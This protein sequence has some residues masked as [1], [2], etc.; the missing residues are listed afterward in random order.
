MLSP[1]DTILIF[2]VALLLFGPEHLPKIARQLGDAMRHVQTTTNAFMAEMERAAAASDR[3][4]PP[5]WTQEPPASHDEI[6]DAAELPSHDS[7]T[8]TTTDPETSAR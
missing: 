5:A 2:V 4:N 3:P 7:A 8:P 1:S 6:T